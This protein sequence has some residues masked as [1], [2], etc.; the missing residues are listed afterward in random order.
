MKRLILKKLVVAVLTFSFG[1]AVDRI[2]THERHVD[3]APQIQAL[4]PVAPKVVEAPPE[5]I[6]GPTSVASPTP[7]LILDYDPRKF[8]PYGS[9]YISGRKPKGFS[10]FDSL[11]L[12]LWENAGHLTGSI[13]VQTHS[14]DVYGSEAAA[15]GL[16]TEK[17]LYFA[18][19]PLSEDTIGYRFDGEFL[20]GNVVSNAP[21]TKVVLRGKLTKWKKGRKIAECMV[22]FRIEVDGC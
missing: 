7:N 12:E 20:Q 13:A 21:E 19:A 22:N 8:V 9:Y 14:N 17:R 6:A 18:T 15:F 10:E 16:V 3:R 4:E 1:V 5:A 11:Y 2:L